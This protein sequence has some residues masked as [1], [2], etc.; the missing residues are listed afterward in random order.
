MS[1]AADA[2]VLSFGVLAND[3]PVQVLALAVA[4]RRLDTGQDAR[5]SN[6]GV[7]VEPLADLEPKA[8]QSDVVGD[9]RIARRSEKD[10]VLAAQHVEPVVGHHDPVRAMV[11]AAPLEVL[12][13]ESI[14][15]ARAR[16]RLED[17]SSAGTTSLPIPSPG[18]VAIRYVFTLRSPSC[19]G[20]NVGNEAAAV[21]RLK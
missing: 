2:G 5:R 6:V 10:R 21:T 13:L 15:A 7:L 16:Q 18:I 1:P 8:P 20:L 3:D 14:V 12:E 17:L 4:Q 19:G 11:V 9:V